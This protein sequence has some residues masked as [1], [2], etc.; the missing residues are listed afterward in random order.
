MTNSRSPLTAENVLLCAF[1]LLSQAAGSAFTFS[2][3]EP[4]PGFDTLIGFGQL[5]ALGYW[6][7]A[8]SMRRGFE[9][10]YCGGIF[11]YVAGVIFIPYYLFKTRG[12]KAFLTLGIFVSVVVIAT[13]A[14]VLAA[15]LMG[16]PRF[17]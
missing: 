15:S 16:A 11:V 17:D 1:I 2:R 3:Q 6:L 13:L 4:P 9:L 5:Y 8:D 12:A 10:P 7:H 14:G